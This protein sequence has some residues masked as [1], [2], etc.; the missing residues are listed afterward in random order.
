[1]IV[2]VLL[3]V[4]LALGVVT[5]IGRYKMEGLLQINHEKST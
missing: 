3:N 1:M 2:M 4:H 5:N